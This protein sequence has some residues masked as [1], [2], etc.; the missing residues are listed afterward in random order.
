MSKVI[1]QK[2]FS[3]TFISLWFYA[4]F[5]YCAKSLA[6]VLLICIFEKGIAVTI[7]NHK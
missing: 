2:L 3:I 5:Y 1:N 7:L 4:F 6:R